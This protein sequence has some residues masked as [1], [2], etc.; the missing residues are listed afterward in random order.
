M[1]R[2]NPGRQEGVGEI[3]RRQS[4]HVR[5]DSQADRR[6]LEAPTGSPERGSAQGGDAGGREEGPEER[7]LS[8][9]GREGKHRGNG[10]EKC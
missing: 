8:I 7:D 3:P 6:Y 1:Q 5:E 9:E 2:A 4:Y 10:Q